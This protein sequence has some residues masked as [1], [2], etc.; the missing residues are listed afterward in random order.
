[1]PQNQCGQRESIGWNSQ[2]FLSTQGRTGLLFGAL[3][4]AVVPVVAP[5]AG[6]SSSVSTI[7][8]SPLAL[9]CAPAPQGRAF[10]PFSSSSEIA[11]PEAKPDWKSADWLARRHI[12]SA[13]ATCC[14]SSAHSR[15]ASRTAASARAIRACSIG[16]CIGNAT[17]ERSPG[18]KSSPD[19][20]ARNVLFCTATIAVGNASL[21]F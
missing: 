12:A 11:K 17:A 9:R 13:I 21:I 4:I 2:L 16:A 20:W 3:A 1:M 15:L 19:D 18:S 7:R 5:I 6:W 14:S 10:Q 8:T